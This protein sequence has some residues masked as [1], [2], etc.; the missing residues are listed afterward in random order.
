M[1]STKR[2]ENCDCQVVFWSANW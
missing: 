2:Y 1:Q